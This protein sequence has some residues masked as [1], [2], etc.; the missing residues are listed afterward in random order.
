MAKDFTEGFYT[1]RAWLMCRASYI[2]ARQSIDGG[3]CEICRDE[4]GFIVHHIVEISPENIGNPE[5]TLSHKNLQY[6][7]LK[8]HNKHHGYFKTD[9]LKREI[10]FDP[11]GNPIF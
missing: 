10:A 9:D 7:C 11:E 2:K 3:M 6:V 1:S 5:I 4:L 8:C